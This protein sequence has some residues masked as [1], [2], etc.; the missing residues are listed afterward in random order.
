VEVARG[1]APGLLDYAGLARRD[2][3]AMAGRARPS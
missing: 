3:T 2:D 1:W